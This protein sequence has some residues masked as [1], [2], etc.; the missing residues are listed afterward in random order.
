MSAEWRPE[1]YNDEYH[2][3]LEKVIQEKIEYGEEK[4]PAPAK[5]KPTNVIDLV[6]VLQRSIQQTQAKPKSGKAAKKTRA[7]NRRRAA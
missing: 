6:S 1:Q 3:V 7:A 2:E 5:K 4:A